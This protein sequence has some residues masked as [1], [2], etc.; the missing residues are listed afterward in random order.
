[1]TIE[2]DE[3]EL[4]R[5]LDGRLSES[6]RSVFLEC[7]DEQ[8]EQW[9]RVALAFVEEQVLRTE[10]SGLQVD[11]LPLPKKTTKPLSTWTLQARNLLAYAAVALLALVVGGLLGRSAKTPSDRSLP[12]AQPPLL[13]NAGDGNTYV[14]LPAAVDSNQNTDLDSV[15]TIGND[16]RPFLT[17]DILSPQSRSE[18]GEQGF[19]VIESPI[20]Y[21]VQ[22]RDGGRYVVPQR[23]VSLVSNQN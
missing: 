23:R 22:D 19:D 17:T 15:A 9:R 1:M 6:E 12:I 10:L 14:L 18:I 2:I 7:V 3:M 16:V 20:I 8:P 21:I 4:Q 5:L 13:E 11:D